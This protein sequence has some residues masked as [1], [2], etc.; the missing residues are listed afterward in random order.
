ME[1]HRRLSRPSPAKPLHPAESLQ[2]ITSSDLL[3]ILQS[4]QL[5]DDTDVATEILD[6][7]E[8]EQEEIKP[9]ITSFEP[10]KKVVRW[11]ETIRKQLA[12]K[13]PTKTPRP[14][15][16]GHIMPGTLDTPSPQSSYASLD[17]VHSTQSD[18]FIFPKK[19]PDGPPVPVEQLLGTAPHD[20]RQAAFTRQLI[21]DDAE[22]LLDSICTTKSP[23][24]I[25][26]VPKGLAVQAK[27]AAEQAGLFTRQRIIT[28]EDESF[29]VLGTDEKEVERLWL[30]LL[31]LEGHVDPAK[32][33]SLGGLS[34]ER[35]AGAGYMG[36]GLGSPS[37]SS[38]EDLT[39]IDMRRTS[40]GGT[41][42]KV[43]YAAGGA[44]AGAAALFTTLAWGS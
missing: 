10:R 18:D 5:T 7:G 4:S 2:S 42:T 21:D 40:S 29:L 28:E 11:Q 25:T 16:R 8:V 43:G 39:A 36:L 26:T 14:F 33:A 9:N 32:F 15:R 12:D 3:D 19:D 22:L 37:R 24:H 44:V 41:P 17:S 6:Y 27:Y 23:G 31:K 34:G 35:G 30:M 13:P 20:T 1:R 38:R